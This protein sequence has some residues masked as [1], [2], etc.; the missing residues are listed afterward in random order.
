MAYNQYNVYADDRRSSNPRWESYRPSDRQHTAQRD[1]RDGRYAKESGEIRSPHENRIPRERR[2]DN[3]SPRPSN[4]ATFNSSDGFRR[5][6]KVSAVNPPDKP[7]D[8]LR[9]NRIN[10]ATDKHIATNSSP[11]GNSTTITV[12]DAKNPKL[13][14]AFQN[15]YS[16]GEKHHKRLL[17]RMRRDKL[18]QERYQHR[19]ENEKFSRGAEKYAPY[20]DHVLDEKFESIYR[21]VDEQIQAIED[22]YRR[23]LEQLV[24][25]LMTN[26]EPATVHCQDPLIAALEAKIEQVSEQAAKQ[27]EQIQNLIE[28]NKSLSTL[29]SE[30]DA[31]RS[32]HDALKSEHK[33]LQSKICTCEDKT[34]ILQSQEADMKS[35]NESLGKQLKELRGLTKDYNMKLA[36]VTKQSID[37]AEAQKVFEI[38]L[39]DRMAGIEAKFDG[40][41]DYGDIK[42]KVDELDMST[43]MEIYSAWGDNTY[44]LKT[45]LAEYSEHR[46]QNGSSISGTFR[47]LR[48]TVDSLRANPSNGLLSDEEMPLLI[49]SIKKVVKPEIEAATT[50]ITRESK[51][52]CEGRDAIIAPMIDDLKARVAIL[53]A[54]ASHP[55]LSKRI[56]SLEQWRVQLDPC[57]DRSQ[58]LKLVERITLLEEGKFGHRIDQI[59]IAVSKLSQD[60]DAL[61]SNVSQLPKHDWVEGCKDSQRKLS[62]LE[63]AFVNLESK[64][65]NLNTKL[66]AEQIVRLTNPGIEQRLGRL[67]SKSDHFESKLSGSDKTAARQTQQIAL[68]NETLQKIRAGEKRTASPSQLDEPGKKRRFEINGRHPSS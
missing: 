23:D 7:S 4:D 15:A 14:E 22:E 36:Q 49:E 31:L 59:D 63:L 44:N 12:P 17:L 19:Q 6:P 25:S 58:G 35:E 62:A 38:G 30:Y 48:Q 32:D 26:L 43:L 5:I 68:L 52:L 10:I 50:L 33:A 9:I 40:F 8:G 60:Y 47:S 41:K 11:A 27:A 65:Q 64:Y 67:E 66:L 20:R 3:E 55:E 16:W 21:A 45:L 56:D 37:A 51:F 18:G 34:R 46:D 2:R 61:K 13:Q 39:S 53:E 28:E 29:K 54:P 57:L 1:S 42:E 24:S